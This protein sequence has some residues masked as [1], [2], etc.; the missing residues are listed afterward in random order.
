MAVQINWNICDNADVCGGI[1]VCPTGALF[2][3][4]DKGSIGINNDLCINCRRC[5]GEDGCPIGAIIVTDTDEEFVQARQII[6]NDTRTKE[7]LFVERYGATPID[8]SVCITEAKSLKRQ[9]WCC[10]C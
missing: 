4:E 1:E 10:P 6:D 2:W 9:R 5:V 3:D 8:E 7:H